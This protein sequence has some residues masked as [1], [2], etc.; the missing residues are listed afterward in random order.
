MYHKCILY[1]GRLWQ[2]VTTFWEIVASL[3]NHMFFLYLVY[4]LLY[5]FPIVVCASSWSLLIFCPVG[6]RVSSICKIL[7]LMSSWLN[8]ECNLSIMSYN[9]IS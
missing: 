1:W 6:G 4:L 8:E 3:V 2:L 5:L 7:K 9:I